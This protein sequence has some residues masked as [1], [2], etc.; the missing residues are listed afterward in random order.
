MGL[1]LDVFDIG[2]FSAQV[3]DPEAFIYL[4]R[5]PAVGT[6]F[7]ALVPIALLTVLLEVARIFR[8]TENFR[9]P[10]ETLSAVR[11]RTALQV[12]PPRM[13]TFAMLLSFNLPVL[14]F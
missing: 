2:A 3:F 1:A 4:Q 7:I 14:I 9:W 12:A 11:E 6:L 13:Y 5:Q 10:G 8:I